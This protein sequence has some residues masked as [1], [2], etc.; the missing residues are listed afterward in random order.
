MGRVGG[1][2]VL[3]PGSAGVSSCLTL[4]HTISKDAMLSCENGSGYD[5]ME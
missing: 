2:P 5:L 4:C 1:Q 3:R